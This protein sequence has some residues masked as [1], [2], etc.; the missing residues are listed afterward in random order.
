M[1]ALLWAAP[2]LLTDVAL[3]LVLCAALW[4]LLSSDQV[5]EALR[6]DFRMACWQ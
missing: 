2:E 6:L 5:H 4:T 3:V 1:M